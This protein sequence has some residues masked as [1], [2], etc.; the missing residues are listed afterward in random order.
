MVEEVTPPEP[1][2]LPTEI[3]KAAEEILPYG[4]CNACVARVKS[5][6][7]TGQPPSVIH[8]A[9][10]VVATKV[11]ET[12]VPTP[13]GGGFVVT[14]I[15]LPMPVCWWDIRVQI[16]EQQPK[17]SGPPR[18]IAVAQQSLP[19]GLTGTSLRDLPTPPLS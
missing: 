2:Y 14:P 12:R 18:R 3:I 7:A 16:T 4:F 9:I 15:L 19:H 8:A 10:T 17:R 5:E 13:D 11:G 1:E 6:I